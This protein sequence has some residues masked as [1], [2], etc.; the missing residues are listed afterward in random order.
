MVAFV[1]VSSLYT[2]AV[3]S[4]Y[5][6]VLIHVPSVLIWLAAVFNAFIALPF[7]GVQGGCWVEVD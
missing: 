4:E 1:T 3:T 6:S 2:F 5:L 7:V